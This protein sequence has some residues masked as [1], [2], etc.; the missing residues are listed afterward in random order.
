MKPLFGLLS[1]I[2]AI[3]AHVPYIISIW[4]GET[5]PHVFSWT[6]RALVG[7]IAAVA[8]YADG[9]GPGMWV[10][11]VSGVTSIGI[12]VF[13]L[14]QRADVEITQVDWAAFFMALAAIPLWQITK[15]PLAAALMA[16]FANLT[17][18]LCCDDPQ[19]HQDE[20]KSTPN[21]IHLNS[22]PYNPYSSYHPRLTG[23]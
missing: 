6:I 22:L 13:A 14:H 1:A 9:A 2:L 11:A 12:A 10:S 16:T 7:I 21:K 18:G 5:K 8:Q 19:N 17:H 4:R 23:Q 15:Q 3:A 20:F